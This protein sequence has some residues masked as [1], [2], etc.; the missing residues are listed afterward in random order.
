MTGT[1]ATE[2]SEFASIYNLTVTVV[3]T[4]KKNQRSDKSDVVYRSMKGKWKAA[5]DEIIKMSQ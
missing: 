5:V 1:A 3:P 4:N 2:A